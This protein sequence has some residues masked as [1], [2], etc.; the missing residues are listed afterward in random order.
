LKVWRWPMPVILKP[1]DYSTRIGALKVWNP[2]VCM[3]LP[4]EVNVL[5]FYVR[6]TRVIDTTSCL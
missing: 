4:R 5:N 3:S 1:I 6:S 2:K